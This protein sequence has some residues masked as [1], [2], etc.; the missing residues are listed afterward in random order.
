VKELVIATRNPHKKKEI[1]ALFGPSKR[2]RLIFLDRYPQAPTIRETGKTFDENAMLKARAI[3]RFTGKPA[4]ADDSGLEVSALGGRPGVRSARFAGE[5]ADDRRNNEK[6]LRLLGSRPL[7]E[8][9][10]HYR[11]SVALALPGGKSY[12]FHGSLSGRIG[13]V[14]QGHL[15]FGY[16][17]LFM[18]P[19]YGKTVA[20]M[21]LALKNRFSHRAR[22]FRRLQKFLA[23]RR[24]L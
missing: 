17:P 16:D 11:C 6:L 15:G 21:P 10:G 7:S 12:L 23:Q 22:A 19:R 14:P 18:V 8:R 3:A 1:R 5:G 24:S 2:W 9:K 4:V 20:Q 13:K